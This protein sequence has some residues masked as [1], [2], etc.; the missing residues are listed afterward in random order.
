MVGES[1]PESEP[2]EEWRID[3]GEDTSEEEEEEVD[4]EVS[5]PFCF[6]ND[7]FGLEL[8]YLWRPDSKGYSA[9]EDS[10]PVLSNY[11]T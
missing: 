6:L 1:E 10:C 7:L 4:D 5:I 2:G 8:A 9:T 3:R 11:N